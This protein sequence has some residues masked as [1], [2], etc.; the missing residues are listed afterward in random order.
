MTGLFLNFRGFM[1]SASVASYYTVDNHPLIV[2]QLENFS[3]VRMGNIGLGHKKL[4]ELV[5]RLRLVD[6]LDPITNGRIQFIALKIFSEISSYSDPTQKILT[7]LCSC[8]NIKNALQVEAV[9]FGGIAPVILKFSELLKA[10]YLTELLETLPQI[11]SKIKYNLHQR[12]ESEKGF[13]KIDTT[14][15]SSYI[16]SIGIDNMPDEFDVLFFNLLLQYEWRDG[17]VLIPLNELPKREFLQKIILEKGVYAK[18]IAQV[19]Y[20]CL[21]DDE[22]LN[23]NLTTR[24]TGYEVIELLNQGLFTNYFEKKKLIPF[25]HLLLERLE[26]AK[27]QG[28]SCQEFYLQKDFVEAFS[29]ITSEN[30]LKE[31]ASV[32]QFVRK[33][34]IGCRK[35]I[36][37]AYLNRFDCNTEKQ[38]CDQH[39]LGYAQLMQL[40][41]TR[42]N[43]AVAYPI[44]KDK[45]FCHSRDEFEILPHTEYLKG[46]R[47]DL[48]RDKLKQT[49]AKSA[50]KPVAK[51]PVK[52][53]SSKKDAF[54]LPASMQE[55]VCMPASA[56]GDLKEQGKV[57]IAETE[58]E[59]EAT[60]IPAASQ[61]GGFLED[62]RL[63]L[64][65]SSL[66][67]R[68]ITIHQ[69]VDS[70]RISASDGLQY[71]RFHTDPSSHHLNEDEMILS[72]RF[73]EIFFTII[74]NEN[75][76]KEQKIQRENGE[77]HTHYRSVVLINKRKYILEATL[78]NSNTLYHFYLKPIKKLSHYYE[79]T[80]E[81][82]A[83][84]P[85]ICQLQTPKSRPL[86]S[87]DLVDFGLDPDGHI[88]IDYEGNNYKVLYLG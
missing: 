86:E 11:V 9:F 20:L 52:K 64:H 44:N 3:S 19:L 12:S 2:A 79:M 77:L 36:D 88:L 65:R 45:P 74:F 27:A 83:E 4:T 10:P 68:E 31:A 63:S 23:Q 69:R 71:Y 30:W 35:F 56:D 26:L 37:K 32:Y 53:K 78:D 51:Q 8:A 15:F 22:T 47:F 42:W 75:Y 62:L 41:K 43:I 14:I 72:H 60:A 67:L 87:L 85:P 28:I 34:E 6:D 21:L 48:S 57:E 16:E 1:A 13:Y 66:F 40:M 59:T 5:D 50:S 7:A 58:T 49:E 73:P 54:P 61:V 38:A 84:F 55:L 80:R 33:I 82:L 17:E 29:R 76:S 81:S 39:V 24:S 70:W 18:L 25:F 46:I